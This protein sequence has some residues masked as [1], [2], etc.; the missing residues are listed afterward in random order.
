MTVGIREMKRG[1]KGWWV[2][3]MCTCPLFKQT[4]N[5]DDP[6]IIWTPTTLSDRWLALAEG[7]KQSSL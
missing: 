6:N 3:W 2:P 4:N 1:D 7:I 5:H